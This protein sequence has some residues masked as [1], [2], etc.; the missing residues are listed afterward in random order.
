MTI[1]NS[2]R[3]HQGKSIIKPLFVALLLLCTVSPQTVRGN[4]ETYRPI[5]QVKAAWLVSFLRFVRWDDPEIPG[6]DIIVIGILGKDP[7]GNLFDYFND[8]PVLGRR[9]EVRKFGRY[10]KGMSLEGCQLIYVGKSE[11]RRMAD[12][13]E[14]MPSKTLTVSELDGFLDKQG[15]IQF[16]VVEQQ[17]AYEINQ[18]SAIEHGI[19][20]SSQLL[21]RARKVI[22]HPKTMTSTP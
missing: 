17:L 16:R 21:A 1:L 5:N 3:S 11:K 19:V 9:L 13:L 4:E 10:K 6:T 22:R 18:K 20:I 14:V 7:Y 8:R 2:M 12:I 15:M